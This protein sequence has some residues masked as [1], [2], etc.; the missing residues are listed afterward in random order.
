MELIGTS[1]MNALRSD[2]I[3]GHRERLPA[4]SE[5]NAD[6]PSPHI[7]VTQT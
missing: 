7:R 6:G 2:E 4:L 5:V 1:R 3:D